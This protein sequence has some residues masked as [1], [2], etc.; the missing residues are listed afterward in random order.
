M[1]PAFFLLLAVWS[2]V[3][4]GNVGRFEARSSLS[5][6][7]AITSGA[8]MKW[9]PGL[10]LPFV[11]GYYTITRQWRSI[12]LVLG[13]ALALGLV[14]LLP[15]Y[16]WDIS[17]FLYAYQYQSS[18]TL[19]GESAWFILQH[20]LDT[21]QLLPDR[22]WGPPPAIL[23]NNEV[24]TVAQI[25]LTLLPLVAAAIWGRTREQWA[26]LGLCSV[27]MFTLAN[28]IFSPQFV[29]LLGFSWASTLVL[30]RPGEKSMVAALVAM[31]VVGL[32]N[33]LVWPLASDNWLWASVAMFVV[34]VALTVG[35]GW[36]ALRG[37]T[38]DA[39]PVVA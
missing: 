32:G 30:L 2:F 21:S 3:R 22:P 27:A 33:F 38:R 34:A 8:L 14:V 35:I 29:I 4:A 17:N 24:I 9:L 11:L 18:R 39:R 19:T 16:V 12:R 15:F 37:P 5:T 23:I 36:R 7:L 26:A 6:G 28:R 1:V 10:L 13:A 20:A 31:V 25:A